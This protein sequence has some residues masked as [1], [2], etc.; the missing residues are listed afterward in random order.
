M[1]CWKQFQGGSGFYLSDHFA[2]MALLDV[3]AEHDRRDRNLELAKKRRAAVARLRDHA[4]LTE[5]QGDVEA[6]RLGS[7]EAGLMRQ[8]AQEE[9]R[10][11]VD[12][13]LRAARL[14]VQKRLD[15][16]R[17]E[18]FGKDSLFDERVVVAPGVPVPVAPASLE[19][20]AL[21]GL[22]GGDARGVWQHLRAKGGD[23]EVPA[24]GG[25]Q[26]AGNTCF[27]NAVLQALLRLPAVALWLSHH[28]GD[29][30]GRDGC[31]LCELSRSK[32]AFACVGA[33]QVPAL[34]NSLSGVAPLASFAD[35]RQHDAEEFL[36]ELLSAVSDGEVR[37]GRCVDWCGLDAVACRATHVER[38]FGFVLERRLRCGPC[39]DGAV[40]RCR[41]SPQFVL[42]LP[43][44]PAEERRRVWTVTELYFLSCGKGSLDAPS[45]CA[46]CGAMTLHCAQ[47]RVLTQPNVLFVHAGRREAGDE[48][49]V[50]RH[51]VQP[52]RE[53]TLPGHDRYDLVAVVYQRGR[54]AKSGH[55][56]CVARAHDDRW[57]RFDDSAPPR[58]FRGDVER[59]E[60]RSVHLL[61][62][63]RPRGQARFAQ[64]GALGSSPAAG[65]PTA[66]A[67]DVADALRGWSLETWRQRAAAFLNGRRC[68]L[69]VAARVVVKE[70]QARLLQDAVLRRDHAEVAALLA[71]L[72]PVATRGGDRESALAQLAGDFA[73]YV[74]GVAAGSVG[75]LGGGRE[76]PS[77]APAAGTAAA[78]GGVPGAGGVAT[79]SAAA[80]AR[81]IEEWPV[82]GDEQLAAQEP[83]VDAGLRHGG[84]EPVGGP[85]VFGP[86][87]ED[88]GAPA[89]VRRATV[90]A[91]LAAG[92]SLLKRRRAV[93]HAS[94]VV[95]K[96]HRKGERPVGPLARAA[97]QPGQER[98][99]TYLLGRRLWRAAGRPPKRSSREPAKG[100]ASSKTRPALARAAAQPGQQRL[101][102][103]A[104]AATAAASRELG[105]AAAEARRERQLRRGVKDR[106]HVEERRAAAAK[107]AAAGTEEVFG[108]PARARLR[109][110]LQAGEAK[111]EAARAAAAAAASEPSGVA[112]DAAA[113]SAEPVGSP[114]TP[115]LAEGAAMAE[116]FS[117]EGT[118]VAALIE[119]LGLSPVR[120]PPAS[121]GASSVGAAQPAGRPIDG[122][123]AV[124]AAPSDSQRSML[125][126]RRVADADAWEGFGDDDD[127]AVPLSIQVQSQAQLLL[128]S[129]GHVRSPAGAVGPLHAKDVGGGWCFFKV[130]AD[131][132][133]S[134]RVRGHGYLAVLAL[135]EVARRR[136]DFAHTVPGSL[137]QLAEPPE[138]RAARRDLARSHRCYAGVVDTLPPFDVMLLDK[139]E[140]VLSGDLHA[141][142]RYAEMY[143]VLALVQSCGLEL[144]IVEGADA[145]GART[146]RTRV[147][148]SEETLDAAVPKL[149]G[150]V[151]DM[152]FVRYEAGAWQHCR[153]VRFADGGLWRVGSE[154]RSRVERR[155]ADCSVCRALARG[156]VGAARALMLS[157]LDPLVAHLL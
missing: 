93:P 10:A 25:L 122:G 17:S 153:S 42:H 24:I 2:V 94:V 38:L 116:A 51:A 112:A 131:Q 30:G 11:D 44:P 41:Y 6:Q 97:L 40:P 55:Y 134:T 99:A 106:Q 49:G 151:L 144:L 139:F 61:V 13:Q 125:K 23:G 123:A 138:V 107:A 82:P 136:A 33:A 28:R 22:P 84:P 52:E 129:L 46:R 127:S 80:T 20:P 19:V 145:P 132:L 4:A 68:D 128:D 74:A 124:P 65:A 26:N 7:E 18:A 37:A 83:A 36:A 64:M 98:I 88:D 66:A 135:V 92:R 117:P 100:G 143:E 113:A 121:F 5:R 69:G 156:Q 76:A 27:A 67:R 90:G 29:C 14:A 157:L 43:T 58:V 45:E 39:G 48:G 9:E 119:S 53:L 59:S 147:Y 86:G 73:A 95:K 96:Q 72:L 54:T 109:L 63:T 1:G 142:R 79:E 115:T 154:A 104:G 141:E 91:T 77:A 35:G 70:E 47:E 62:Y 85:V 56:Y 12:A 75:H 87:C 101:D 110:Q 71:E 118:H 111:A 126:R 81:V 102:A 130:F 148:P 108:A 8:R 152:V 140:G 150:G 105:A 78:A 31:L 89:P 103:F 146:M 34:V 32:T 155:V 15:R 133:G 137:F 149:R 16:L 60:L 21:R 57:W 120:A 114:R 50:L 3:D